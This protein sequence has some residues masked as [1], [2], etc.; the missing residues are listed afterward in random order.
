MDLR[1]LGTTGLIVS[2]IGLG[3]AA[4]GRP[5]Y[6]TLGRDRDLG[7]DRSISQMEARCHEMLDAAYAAGIRYVDAAR[8]YGRAEEF[9]ASFLKSRWTRGIGPQSPCDIVVG[10]KWGYTYTADWQV[11]A[12]AHE[13]KDLSRATLDRQIDESRALLGSSLQLY[14]IHSATLESGVLNDTSVLEGLMRL[15]DEGMAI[16]LTVSGPRQAETIR[17]ALTVRVDGVNPFQAV[18]ATWNLLEVSAA[19]ALAEAHAAGM[20][21]IIKEGL[22]NGRLTDRGASEESRAAQEHAAQ[23]RC[24]LDALAIAAAVN[25]PWV[26]VV[27]SGA[28]TPEQLRSNLSAIDRPEVVS[29]IP[30]VAMPRDA[31]WKSRSVLNWQ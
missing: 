10:S 16:G 4:L 31:Y 5:G 28:V 22:A 23:H 14:Q 30:S 6:I 20:G 12:E 21:I 19:P 17:R 2:R 8:S 3:L 13:V 11:T 29:G 7:G 15:R 18:Q 27:L 24:S 1:L 26:D 25:Q 9:L